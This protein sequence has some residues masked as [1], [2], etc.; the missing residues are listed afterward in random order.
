MYADE[1]PRMTTL[2]IVGATGLVGQ[3]LLGQALLPPGVEQVV[4][5]VRR[6]VPAQSRVLA[7]LVD[8]DHLPSAARWWQVDAVICTLGTT[9]KAAGSRDAFRQ[10]DHAY[11]LQVAA[12]ARRHGVETFVLTS[13]SGANPRSRVFYS[14]TKG[15]LERD[16][17]ALDFGS[18]TFV[19]PALLGGTRVQ[20]RRAEAVGLKLLGAMRPLLPRRYRVVAAEEVARCLLQAALEPQPGVRVIESEAIGAR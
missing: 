5:P 2:M 3:A 4:S 17:I 1:N 8:F 16:L 6:S 20:V 7:P 9:L 11:P 14:R 18:L 10:V 12:I 13:A 19:R 15:E